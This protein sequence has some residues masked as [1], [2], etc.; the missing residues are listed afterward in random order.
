MPEDPALTIREYFDRLLMEMDKRNDQRFAF[1]ETAVAA[2][3]QSAKEAVIKAEVS[4]ENRLKNTNEW[5]STV[6]GLI[7]NCMPKPEADRALRNLEEKISAN[8]SLVT[9]LIGE[10]RGTNAG[11]GYAVGA[12]GIII[13]IMSFM[14]HA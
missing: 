7:A 5:R 4:V 14:R 10:K 11:W 13:A 9:A 6:E 12:I 3:L 8:T 1:Q 2:A